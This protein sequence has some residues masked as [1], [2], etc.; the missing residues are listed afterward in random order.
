MRSSRPRVAR[1]LA[2]SDRKCVTRKFS[3]PCS[4]PFNDQ[5]IR[6]RSSEG[7]VVGRGQPGRPFDALTLAHDKPWFG[8][9]LTLPGASPFLNRGPLVK[10]RS[11][12]RRRRYHLLPNPSHRR[13]SR[14]WSPDRDP[15]LDQRRRFDRHPSGPVGRLFRPL[16]CNSYW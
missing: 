4:E 9:S 16:R 6:A 12:R 10:R 5:L 7:D 14:Q 8:R 15:G 11:Y 2:S 3:T 13:R 1:S